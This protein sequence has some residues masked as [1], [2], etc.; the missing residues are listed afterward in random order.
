MSDEGLTKAA[1]SVAEHL[2]TALYDIDG[3]GVG[4]TLRRIAG[5]LAALREQR[6]AESKAAGRRRGGRRVVQIAVANDGDQNDPAPVLVA[7]CD[8]GTVWRWAYYA[9]RRGW[10]WCKYEPVPQ[11]SV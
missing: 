5:E 2:N 6:V 10:T 9:H 4:E 8:D 1:D 3:I 11:G 7:L